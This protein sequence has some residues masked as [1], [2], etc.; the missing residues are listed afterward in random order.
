M[1]I[2]AVGYLLSAPAGAILAGY[3][4]ITQHEPRGLIMAALLALFAMII[5]L[6][7]VFTFDRMQRVVRW[8]GRTILE[9]H[10]RGCKRTD[11]RS[12]ILPAEAVQL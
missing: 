11:G 9:E 12:G 8:K 7:K 5:D 10:F 6:R 1:W 3:R 4:T 2:A